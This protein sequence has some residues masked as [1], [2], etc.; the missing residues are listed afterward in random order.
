MKTMPASYESLRQPTSA[1]MMESTKPAIEKR[2]LWIVNDID[3]G[4]I[5]VSL[6]RPQLEAIDSLLSLL[7]EGRLY[8]RAL[9]LAYMYYVVGV[10]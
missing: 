7:D 4:A 9:W 1:E 3:S 2:A 8:G 6:A 5:S 10:S